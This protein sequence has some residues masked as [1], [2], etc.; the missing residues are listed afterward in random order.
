MQI[1]NQNQQQIN[2]WSGGTTT[3][4]FIYPTQSSYLNRD[5]LFRI[6]TATVDED[7]SEFTQLLGYN[8][9][10]MLIDGEL[11][12][13]HQVDNFN[14]INADL[15]PYKTHHF[16]GAWPTTAIGRVVDFNVIFK[17]QITVKMEHLVLAANQST[18][19]NNNTDFMFVYVTL[20]DTSIN[21]NKSTLNKGDFA[22]INPNTPVQLNTL[23]G[24]TF[25]ITYINLLAL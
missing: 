16:N 6:S 17:P 20:G 19:I 14:T 1:I 24:C 18:T 4:L 13:T 22:I 25:I 10:L 11:K 3:Q 2:K 8:R 21:N 15:K 12:I 7:V 5:F 9:L 23:N